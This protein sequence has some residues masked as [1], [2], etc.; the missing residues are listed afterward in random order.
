[1]HSK[2]PDVGTTIFTVMSSLANAC[3]AINLSQGFPDFPSDRRLIDLVSKYMQQGYNQYAPMPGV[4]VLRER[5]SQKIELLYG[6]S[7]NPDTEIT[8]TSGATQAIFSAITAFVH[9]GDEVIIV[10]PAY[11]CYKPAIELNG[12]I[13]VQYTLQFPDYE[14]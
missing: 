2:L 11:D 9:P 12:G 10:E 7:V 5:L 13:A 4:K 3:N 1:M 8:I 6:L 14:H